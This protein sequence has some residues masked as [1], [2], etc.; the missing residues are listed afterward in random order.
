MKS[1]SSD[2]DLVDAAELHSAADDPSLM[3]APPNCIGRYG[4]SGG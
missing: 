4:Y 2:F 3:V 1:D